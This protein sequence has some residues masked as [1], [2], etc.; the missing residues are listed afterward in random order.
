M[1]SRISLA[2]FGVKMTT[3]SVIEW[4]KETTALFVKVQ[5]KEVVFFSPL[6]LTSPCKIEHTPS[7]F[8]IKRALFITFN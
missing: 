1:Q 3:G 7:N 6:P 5:L 2:L 4:D 8:T